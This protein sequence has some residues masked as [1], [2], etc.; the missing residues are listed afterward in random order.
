MEIENLSKY[1]RRNKIY[2]ENSNT[3]GCYFC[4]NIFDPKEIIE[5]TDEGE[6][7]ICPKCHVDSIVGDSTL[8]INHKFLEEASKYW[9]WDN[10]D[11]NL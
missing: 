4:L 11:H 5:W 3:C 2:L 8:E 9:F 10:G 1:S 6:T 7:A